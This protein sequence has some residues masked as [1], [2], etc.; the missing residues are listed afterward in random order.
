MLKDVVA[1]LVHQFQRRRL[2][3]SIPVNKATV[4]NRVHYV[5]IYLIQ[6]KETLLSLFIVSQLRWWN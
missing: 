5:L 2:D 6:S 4:N 1:V 3:F